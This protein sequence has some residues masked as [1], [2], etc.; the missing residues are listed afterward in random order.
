MPGFEDSDSEGIKMGGGVVKIKS[1]EVDFSS[2]VLCALR[3]VMWM[4]GRPEGRRLRFSRHEIMRPGTR[5]FVVGLERESFLVA[6][7]V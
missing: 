3:Q 5:V 4:S 7:P 1:K 2:S 6:W